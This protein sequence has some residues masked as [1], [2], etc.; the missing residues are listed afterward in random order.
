MNTVI[1]DARNRLDLYFSNEN[2]NGALRF[3]SSH[4]SSLGHLAYLASGNGSQVL[5]HVAFADRL[6]LELFLMRIGEECPQICNCLIL[7]DNLHDTNMIQR[8]WIGLEDSE[9]SE[10]EELPSLD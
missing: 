9:S 5:F 8:Y 4:S 2:H 1:A 3:D 7:T 10:D 6:M